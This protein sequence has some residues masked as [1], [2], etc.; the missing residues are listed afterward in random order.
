MAV[1]LQTVRSGNGPPKGISTEECSQRKLC[2]KM[3]LQQRLAITDNL[4]FLYSLPLR[5]RHTMQCPRG[6]EE[7]ELQSIKILSEL[8]MTANLSLFT[9]GVDKVF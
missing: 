4:I 7:W 2:P 8:G 1:S 6:V 5:Q 9:L 3:T